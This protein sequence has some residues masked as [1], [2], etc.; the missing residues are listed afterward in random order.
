LGSTIVNK[1]LFFEHEAKNKERLRKKNKDRIVGFLKYSK[2]RLGNGKPK[3]KEGY[4]LLLNN[5]ST[6]INIQS[7]E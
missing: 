5:N 4:A 1:V 3:K 2:I 6:E 7:F